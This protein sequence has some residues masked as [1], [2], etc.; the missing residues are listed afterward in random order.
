MT[1]T[2]RPYAV[3]KQSS[4]FYGRDTYYVVRNPGGKR[5]DRRDTHSD[6]AGAQMW[7]DHLNDSHEQ[8]TADQEM[9]P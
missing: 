6:R 4:Q 2:R 8:D 5:V 1:T 3:R 7:A 9:T